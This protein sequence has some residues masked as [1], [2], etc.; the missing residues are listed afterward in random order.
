MKE[1]TVVAKNEVGSLA[2]VAEALG[3]VGVNIEAISA[4]GTDGNAIFRFIT[5]DPAT[6][7]KVLSKIE[8]VKVREGETI[9]YK[10]INRPGELGK[11]TRKLAQKGINLESI[12]IMTRKPDFTEI[13]LRTVEADIQKAKEALSIKD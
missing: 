10:M 4:Y 8:G 3:H 1:V 6:A 13:A 2:S 9:I 11:L 7:T 12:Y 5:G